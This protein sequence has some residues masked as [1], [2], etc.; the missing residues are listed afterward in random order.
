M[1]N[2]IDA[3]SWMEDLYNR[4]EAFRNIPINK[5]L[6]P[7]SHDSGTSKMSSWAKTQSRTIKEQLNLGIRYFD[8][9]PKVHKSTFYV[10]HSEVGPDGSADLGHY[11]KSI[12]PDDS[13]NNKY[14]FKD[15]RD[16]LISHPKEIVI[17]KFQ[18]FESF[19]KQ[20]YYDF[21]DLIKAYFTFDKGNSVCRLARFPHGTGKDIAGQTV[22][23]VL[24]T[25][26]RVFI[27]W[28][29]KDVPQEPKA[30]EIWDFAFYYTPG[31]SQKSPFCLWDPY[32]HDAD[33]SLADDRNS[34]EMNRWWDWHRK[35][36]DAWTKNHDAGFFVLQSQMQQLP[37]GDAD[38]SASRNNCRNIEHYIA[39]A[40]ANVPMNIMTFD[41]VNYGDL[42]NKIIAYYTNLFS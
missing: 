38:A 14:I 40:K 4:Y 35:N 30:K 27:V 21:I 28:D 22:G 8:L 13:S 20:D 2:T 7:G 26:K 31:L 33:D 17:L 11:S 16:F 5:L 24:D 15:I 34:A 6:I 3:G 19:Y 25:H 9:R 10:H 23:S 41:F 12:Q 18:N 39:W 1:P 29:A 42:C 37:A 36:L 32:W